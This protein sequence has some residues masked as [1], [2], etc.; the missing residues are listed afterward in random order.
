MSDYSGSC[1]CGDVTFRIEGKFDSFYLCHCEYCQKDSGSSNSANL[2]SHDALLIWMSGEK[3]VTS[4]KLTNTRHTKC[5]CSKCGSALPYIEESTSLIVVPAGSLD[6]DSQISPN[7]H[8]FMAS[9]ATWD[10]LLGD[11]KKFDGLP[12][13]KIK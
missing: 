6:V 9:R 5:F 1:L 13:N 7:A 11:L 3:Q 8:I 4:F 12:K 10:N 2:F